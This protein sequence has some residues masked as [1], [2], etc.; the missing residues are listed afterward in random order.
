M[1]ERR[2]EHVYNCSEEVFWSQIFLDDEYNR[3]LFMDELHFDRWRVVSSEERDGEIH[4]LVEAAPRLGDLPAALKRLLTS[5]LGYEERG[6]VD[7]KA[8]R[9]RLKV[10]PRSLSSKLTITGELY[11]TALGDAQCRRTY[12]A[13]VEARVFGIAGLIENRILDDVARSYEKAAAFTNRWIADH[14]Y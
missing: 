5:G 6:I 1:K 2:I 7:P 12:V 8:R 13:G 10:T 11:T 14:E 9:Y 3:T 4:R